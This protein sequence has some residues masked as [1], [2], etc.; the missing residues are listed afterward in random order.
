MVIQ[1]NYI[2]RSR[3]AILTVEK[4][5]HHVSQGIVNTTRRVASIAKRIFEVVAQFFKQVTLKVGSLFQKERKIAVAVK[6]Q[7][8]VPTPQETPKTADFLSLTRYLPNCDKLLKKAELRT[9]EMDR[10]NGLLRTGHWNEVINS[11][12]KTP[13]HLA[14]DGLK[15]FQRGD[16]TMHQFAT[17]ITCWSLMIDFPDSHIHTQSL[18]DGEGSIDKQ[19]NKMIQ[20]TL[21]YRGEEFIHSSDTEKRM[22]LQGDQLELFFQKM[23]IQP[24]SEKV[25]FFVTMNPYNWSK[26]VHEV[27]L[28]MFSKKRTVMEHIAAYLGINVFHQ[29]TL[30]STTYRMVPSFS[31]MQGFVDVQGSSDAVKLTP[32]IGLSSVEDMM[33]NIKMQTRDVALPFPGV[34]LPQEADKIRA[35]YAVEF[36][37]HD[38]FHCIIASEIP[39]KLRLAIQDIVDG[40][41]EVQVTLSGDQE[42]SQ[43]FQEWCERVIDMDFPLFSKDPRDVAVFEIPNITDMQK[44]FLTIDGTKIF[45]STRIQ[46]EFFYL[47]NDKKT[48]DKET[49][50]VFQ[51][52]QFH[53]KFV[54]IEYQLRHQQVI[55]KVAKILHEANFCKKHEVSIKDLE[56]LTEVY[57]QQTATSIEVFKNIRKNLDPS[58]ELLKEVTYGGKIMTSI[59]AKIEMMRSANQLSLSYH[60]LQLARSELRSHQI[61]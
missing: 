38:F 28:E 7:E 14:T 52:L 60:L 37:G 53:Q 5:M 12:R 11:Y 50:K 15:A 29:V 43:F 59:E 8:H 18:F 23:K 45:A 47:Q 44:L 13:D 24:E 61:G 48:V 17:L 57:E 22:F 9:Q 2:T 58:N 39:R 56:E 21:V 26:P 19:A 4:G 27:Y 34:K 51:N 31:M 10:L 30:D 36:I 46:L 25:F 42:V 33:M 35:P 54:N 3:A 55:R 40:M 16:I 6:E 32:V 41:R 49:Y 20:D 1:C